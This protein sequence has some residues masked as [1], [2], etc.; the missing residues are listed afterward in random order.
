MPDIIMQ[1][2]W[3]FGIKDARSGMQDTRHK[4]LD[5]GS[6][7][8]VSSI[9]HLLSHFT[10]IELLVVIA[11]I[12]ILCALLLPALANAKK[13][14]KLINCANNLKNIGTMAITYASDYDAVLPPYNADIWYSARFE[15]PGPD[16][17]GYKSFLDKMW[18]LM[19]P[20]GL[21]KNVGQCPFSSN[22]GNS[23]VW[24]K[25]WSSRNSY[26]YT[27]TDYSTWGGYWDPQTYKL[28]LLTK[29]LSGT[30][31]N[32]MTPAQKV[33]VKD[34]CTDPTDLTCSYA[35]NHKSKSG[36]VESQ[37]ILF[38]DGHT[39]L[40]RSPNVSKGVGLGANPGCW[41]NNG[42]TIN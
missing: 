15:N 19:I 6:V 7:H 24:M 2:T 28:L 36:Y 20:Y 17:L 35:N 3:K 1:D 25:T 31:G 8:P 40:R 12:A 29:E 10:L 27:M 32:P 30:F 42:A 14:A 39:D 22:C 37:N 5:A 13:T 33:I 38:L 23:A 34:T 16:G 21:N 26:F 11:I 18:A 9:K 41:Y 4:T